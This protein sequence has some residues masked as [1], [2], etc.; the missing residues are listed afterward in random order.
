MLHKQTFG[1]KS[2][3]LSV[4]NRESLQN[5]S[6]RDERVISSN[7]NGDPQ[8]EIDQIPMCLDFLPDTSVISDE[9]RRKVQSLAGTS[10]W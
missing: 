7:E 3:Q 9:V 8:D 5:R 2:T 4:N 1:L 10:C 6:S